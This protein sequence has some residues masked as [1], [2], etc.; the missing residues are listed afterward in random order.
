MSWVTTGLLRVAG[1]PDL[2]M[3]SLG[4]RSCL[5]TSDRPWPG[6]T[7]MSTSVYKSTLYCR[8][9]LLTPP[10]SGRGPLLPVGSECLR[11]QSHYSSPP[12]GP[13]VGSRRGRG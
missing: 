6:S 3:S 7:Q 5:S 8:W 4:S 11:W 10:C 9:P 12:L 1:R 2:S 13:T